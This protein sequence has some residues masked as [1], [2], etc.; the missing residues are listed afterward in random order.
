MSSV[1]QLGMSSSSEI[2]SVVFEIAHWTPF[3]VSP[4]AVPH[5]QAWAPLLTVEITTASPVQFAPLRGAAGGTGNGALGADGCDG[6]VGVYSEWSQE[7]SNS[8]VETMA[9]TCRVLIADL[10]IP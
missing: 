4:G 2:A 9:T 3:R 7:A 1:G 8:I 10:A 5:P 6:D